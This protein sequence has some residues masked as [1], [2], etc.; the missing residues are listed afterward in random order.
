VLAGISAGPEAFIA[1]ASLVNRDVAAREVV[2]GVP[3]RTLNSS[4]PESLRV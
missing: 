4:T 2:G 1:A 3:I